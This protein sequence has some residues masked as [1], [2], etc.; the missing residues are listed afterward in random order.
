MAVRLAMFRSLDI[1]R[2]TRLSVFSDRVEV[3]RRYGRVTRTRRIDY[4][5]L[6]S[7]QIV[8]TKGSTSVVM[9]DQFGI[10][11]VPLLGRSDARRARALIE[12]LRKPRG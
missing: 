4:D 2:P 12:G 8:D 7:V 10:V 11:P 1:V 6:S 9:V 5:G 3:T